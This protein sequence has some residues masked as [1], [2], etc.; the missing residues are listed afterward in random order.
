MT[1]D[2]VKAE[3]PANAAIREQLKLAAWRVDSWRQNVGSGR[4]ALTLP[5]TDR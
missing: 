4:Q 1:R 3:R 5:L 2:P